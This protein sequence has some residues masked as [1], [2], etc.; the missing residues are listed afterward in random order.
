MAVFT[1]DILLILI[2][3]GTVLIFATV[4]SIDILNHS[5]ALITPV[6]LHARHYSVVQDGTFYHPATKLTFLQSAE[7]AGTLGGAES[8]SVLTPLLK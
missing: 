5:S 1:L 3:L 6:S 8:M 4:S 7:R 2:R